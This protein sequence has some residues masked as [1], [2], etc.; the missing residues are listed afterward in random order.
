MYQQFGSLRLEKLAREISQRFY[1]RE[2]A[3]R[4]KISESRLLITTGQNPD[5]ASPAYFFFIY[6]WFFPTTAWP[7]A[8]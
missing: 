4:D 1:V 5:P 8:A 6:L 2:K 3:D 7:P